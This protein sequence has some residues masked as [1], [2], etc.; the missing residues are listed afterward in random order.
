MAVIMKANVSWDATPCSLVAR[1][2]R[3]GRTCCLHLQT[4][5]HFSAPKMEAAGFSERL[6]PFNMTTRC[7]MFALNVGEHVSI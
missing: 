1:N 6:A 3:L 5:S 4:G 7:H 2:Q